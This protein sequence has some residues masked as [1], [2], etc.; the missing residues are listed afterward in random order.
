M[1]GNPGCGAGLTCSAAEPDTPLGAAAV[2]VA[3][4]VATPVA[5]PPAF[6]VAIVAS[7]VVQVKVTPEIGCWL[8]SNAAAVNAWVPP[9]MIVALAGDTVTLATTG[10]GGAVPSSLHAPNVLSIGPAQ[11]P[12]LLRC[13]DLPSGSVPASATAM[14]VDVRPLAGP[15]V[16]A[17][18][19]SYDRNSTTAPVASISAMPSGL[20]FWIPF[21]G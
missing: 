21:E 18:T 4:P 6:T 1:S 13:S 12:V 2:I 15:L 3:S 7:L 19:P 11:V 10:G 14:S 16:A 5:T 17:N 8:A 9:T 20:P